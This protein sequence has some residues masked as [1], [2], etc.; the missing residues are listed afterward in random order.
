[1]CAWHQYSDFFY[2]KVIMKK[3]FFLVLMVFQ[4]PFISCTDSLF[5][6]PTR[7]H[8]NVEYLHISHTRTKQNPR[9]DSDVEKVDFSKYDMLWLG[10]DLAHESS[11]DIRTMENI[12]SV[13]NI[14]SETTLWS[15]GNHDYSNLSR[16]SKYTN[17]N[18]YYAYYRNGITV[19]VLDTQDDFSNISGTQKVF[20]NNVI[21]SLDQSSHLV[22]LHHKL[23]WMNDNENLEAL[24][25][26]T[27][28]GRAGD[29]FYCINPNNFYSEIYPKL[30]QVKQKGIEVIC[31][32]G[33]I[34]SK[35]S[36]FEFETPDGIFFIA[37]GIFS[38]GAYNKALLF[39]HNKKLKTLVWNYKYIK[40][41]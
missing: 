40:D 1:V 29:C 25:Y 26:Y 31:I 14:G 10:G 30:K 23:I 34:G 24:I 39:K 3:N 18:P 7:S 22:V 38:E 32:G 19:I 6:E 28:N 21:D 33:D 36:E 27:S 5:P 2:M 37:S 13:F 20:F 41:L 4:L 12:N 11:K 15:L 9:M 17:R 16:V 35:T 8:E